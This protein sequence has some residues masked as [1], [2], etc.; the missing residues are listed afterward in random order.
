[1]EVSQ[2][3]SE[4]RAPDTPGSS[5]TVLEGH[6]LGSSARM[7]L[8]AS[9]EQ[10]RPSCLEQLWPSQMV[11]KEKAAYC[12]GTPCCPCLWI[13]APVAGEGFQR[14]S[15]RPHAT[16]HDHPSSTLT[17]PSPCAQQP[18]A[19]DANWMNSVCFITTCLPLFD[20]E[21]LEGRN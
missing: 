2:R 20:C 10:A 13:Q 14:P 9:K 12:L 5:W 7:V 19:R 8:H 15:V 21:F 1:M 16:H 18:A 6:L 4:L 17:A 11:R 3:G